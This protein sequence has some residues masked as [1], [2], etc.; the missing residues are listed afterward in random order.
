MTVPSVRVVIRLVCLVIVHFKVANSSQYLVKCNRE[1]TKCLRDISSK[2]FVAK[3]T[4]V[5]GFYSAEDPTSP[6]TT[7]ETQ[8]NVPGFYSAED[9]TSPNTTDETQVVSDRSKF[10]KIAS[11][12]RAK[13]KSI[14]G[15]EL[16][17]EQI[18]EKRVKKTRDTYWNDMW[19]VN[20]VVVPSMKVIEA[21]NLGYSGRGVYVAVVDDGVDISH[22]DLFANT[23]SS[24]HYDYRIDVSDPSPIRGDMHGT[25]CAGLVGAER[26]NNKCI[27]GIAYK[28][29]IVGIRLLGY[30]TTD[31]M[32]GQSLSHALSH[33]DIYSNSWGPEDGYGFVSLRTHTSAAIEHGIRNGRNGKGSIYVWAAGNGGLSDNCNADGFVKSIYT[34][35]ISSI[36]SLKESATYAEVCTPVMAV[37]YG[38]GGGSNA[39][40]YSTKPGNS[41]TGHLEGTS[42]S[43]PEAAAIIALTLEAKYVLFHPVLGFGLMDAEAMVKTAISWRRVPDQKIY[44]TVTSYPNSFIQTWNVLSGVTSQ[45]SIQS[46]ETSIRYLEHVIVSV[47]FKSNSIGDTE[48]QLLSPD[49]TMSYLLTSRP[50]EVGHVASVDW[51]YMTVHHWGESPVGTWTLRMLVSS[52]FYSGMLNSWQITFYGTSQDPGNDNPSETRNYTKSNGE[53]PIRSTKSSG[54]SVHSTNPYDRVTTHSTKSNGRVTTHSTKS[55]GRVTTH[56]T[57]LNGLAH[58]H[59]NTNGYSTRNI[60]GIIVCSV[61]GGIALTAKIVF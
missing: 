14:E 45:I 6:N 51:N 60:L 26:D 5:P 13:L 11:K 3:E 33:I 20:G 47:Y 9:P 53:V 17:E 37:T 48:L 52:G 16:V 59:S 31:M 12:G 55:N 7:D 30:G 39:Y 54:T 8:T 44:T 24:Y 2:G 46:Y 18:Y 36:N 27:A 15:V 49:G 40:L 43:A 19:A 28:A 32:E 58:L 22:M 41:C 50:L 42:F 29:S 61:C 21:W 4:N 38:G 34:I 1:N 25:N 23:R 57:K 35:A 56:S 10:S